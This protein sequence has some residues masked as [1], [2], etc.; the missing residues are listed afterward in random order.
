MIYKQFELVENIEENS[1]VLRPPERE[2]YPYTPYEFESNEE[3]AFFMQK[4]R[5]ITLDELYTICKSYFLKYVDQDEHIIVLLAADS[6]GP[7]SK[8]CFQQLIIVK[9]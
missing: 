4:A 5:E 1:R 2:E 9:E 3:L 8:I 6:I 7:I